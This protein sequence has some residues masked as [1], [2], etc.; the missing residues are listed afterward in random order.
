MCVTRAL[1][2]EVR[3]TYK[4]HRV[5]CLIT[6]PLSLLLTRIKGCY[7]STTYSL[8]NIERERLI[9]S[10]SCGIVLSRSMY[11]T[12]LTILTI[13]STVYRRFLFLGTILA[14][15]VDVSTTKFI[16]ASY[17]SRLISLENSR[18][19]LILWL[20]LQLTA[21]CENFASL[22]FRRL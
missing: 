14:V 16:F 18:N 19:P 21:L 4:D 7:G 1:G 20:T 9:S 10:A 22:A 15:S 12:I 6:P 8:Y 3:L 13:L 2:R 17:F 11:G 5:L